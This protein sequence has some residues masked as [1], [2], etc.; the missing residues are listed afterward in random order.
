MIKTNT[1]FSHGTFQLDVSFEDTYDE[2]SI[3]SVELYEFDSGDK[4][5]RDPYVL[6][7]NNDDAYEVSYIDPQHREKGG[8]F[9]YRFSDRKDRLMKWIVRVNPEVV[10]NGSSYKVS[11]PCCA[12]VDEHGYIV[13]EGYAAD[14]TEYQKKMLESV[15]LCCNGCEVP[16]D[17]INGLLNLFTVKA[18]V[19][20]KSPYMEMIFSKYANEG[21]RYTNLVNS[22]SR[23][24]NCNG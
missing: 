21:G 7:A 8:C 15:N 9:R 12:D 22:F 23:K 11:A 17:I 13:F 20:S 5:G 19:Q 6:I 10:S 18:A 1:I 24:C 4:S 2:L 16:K 3:V 14:M